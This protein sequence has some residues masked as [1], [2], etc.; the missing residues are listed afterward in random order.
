MAIM[1]L[2][3]I[4]RKKQS[5]CPHSVGNILFPLTGMTFMLHTVSS[6]TSLTNHILGL[7]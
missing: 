4:V 6:P 3:F 7:I 1:L 2:T 5:L